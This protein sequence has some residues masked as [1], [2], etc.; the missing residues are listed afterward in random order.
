MEYVAMIQGKR[1]VLPKRTLEI[2]SQIERIERMSKEYLSGKVQREQ[3]VETQYNFVQ[4]CTENALE[5]LEA[6]DTNELL[7]YAVDILNIYNAPAIEAQRRATMANISKIVNS[8][9]FGKL[10]SLSNLASSV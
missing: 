5:D 7:Q 9:E 4:H 1:H 3:I 10:L 6:V 2:D 8:P